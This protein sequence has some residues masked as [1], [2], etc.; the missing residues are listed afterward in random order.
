MSLLREQG[1]NLYGGKALLR[2]ELDEM[3]NALLSRAG[4]VFADWTGFMGGGFLAH[5]YHLAA[6]SEGRQ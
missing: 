3:P 1:G 4:F 6:E 2:T 5:L